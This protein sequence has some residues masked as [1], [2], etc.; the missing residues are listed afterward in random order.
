MKR[1]Y[2][3]VVISAL[4][5]LL[6]ACTSSRSYYRPEGIRPM[7]S[8]SNV[9]SEV[10]VEIPALNQV[11]NN[12]FGKVP[13]DFQN[14]IL[15]RQEV[16]LFEGPEPVSVVPDPRTGKWVFSRP[17]MAIFE[18]SG[19]NSERNW[20]E[21]QRIYLPRNSQFV[22]VSRAIGIFGKGEPVTTYLNT[23]R[24]P[25][26]AKYWSQTPRGGEVSAGALVYLNSRSPAMNRGLNAT[27]DLDL[28]HMGAAI[29]DVITG[30]IYGQ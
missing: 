17:F 5:A 28:R 18:V 26:S 2:L 6:T 1:I 16:L 19:A 20:H 13:V 29:T 22:V 15:L 21:Y 14:P 11:T 12:G 27:I 9:V 7:N 23:G 3:V 24:D 4:L 8:Q 30:V 10:T 25:Y